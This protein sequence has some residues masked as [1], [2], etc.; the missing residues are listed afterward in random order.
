MTIH[1]STYFSFIDHLT[2]AKTGMTIGVSMADTSHGPKD[3]GGIDL[4]MFAKDG[5]T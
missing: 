3:V 2:W 1:C 5:E 4:F